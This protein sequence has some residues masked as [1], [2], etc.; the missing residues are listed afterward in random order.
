M[1]AIRKTSVPMPGYNSEYG[2]FEGNVAAYSDIQLLGGLHARD[3]E[4]VGTLSIAENS[5][6]KDRIL[7]AIQKTATE[8]IKRCLRVK[9]KNC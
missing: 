7:A 8:E 6:L 2:I 9:E 4:Y 3:V 1:K 5:P